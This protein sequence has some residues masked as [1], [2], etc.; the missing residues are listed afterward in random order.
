MLERAKW[1]KKS[2]D[3]SSKLP[4][5]EQY[6]VTLPGKRLYTLKEAAVFLGRS[7]WGILELVWA[8]KLPVV[9]PKGS[10]KIYIDILDLEEFILRNKSLYSWF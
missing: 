8:R 6:S 3:L 4:I 5:V 1:Q 10:R 2:T 7:E 9:M